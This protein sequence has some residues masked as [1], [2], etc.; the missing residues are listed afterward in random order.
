M[1]YRN[2]STAVSHI[3]D[4][5]GQGDFTTIGAALTAA[6]SGQT[7]FVRPGTYTENLTLKGGVNLCA[8]NC[9]AQSQNVEIVGKCS[10]TT[11]GVV[12]ISGIN[13]VTNSDYCISVSGSVASVLLIFNCNINANNHTSILY[14]S[15]SGGSSLSIYY[16]RGFIG[17]SGI[18]MFDYSAAG[19]FYFK[20]NDFS[21]GNGNSTT[22]NTSSGAELLI[23][24]SSLNTP[25]TTSGTGVLVSRGNVY[26]PGGNVT[27]LIAGSTGATLSTNDIYFSGSASAISISMGATLELSQSCV[28]S[29][30]TNAITGAGTLNAGII[31]FLSTGSTINTST[32]N[33]LTTYG[34]TIV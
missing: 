29:S 10:L 18:A 1:A 17:T 23:E 24:F 34:G 19:F 25:I 28:S 26:T 8:L 3:V 6:S 12:S 2:Y 20:Y 22:A 33:K 14:S 5:T 4:A 31:T 27:C 21:F 32:V 15:S 9:D 16:S 13:F 11:A 30:N 7:I